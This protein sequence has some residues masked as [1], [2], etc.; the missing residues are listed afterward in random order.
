MAENDVPNKEFYR[1]A[2]WSGPNLAM[3]AG[4]TV[5][6][7]LFAPGF[8][9]VAAGWELAWMWLVPNHPRW[10]R[11]VRAEYLRVRDVK[12]QEELDGMLRR[13]PDYERNK[14]REL[15][16]VTQRIER[17]VEDAPES[18]RSTMEAGVTR[19]RDLLKTYIRMQTS[20]A[21]IR[22]FVKGSEIDD[23]QRQIRKLEQEL[24]DPAMADALRRVKGSNLDV[25]NQRLARALKAHEN[26]RVL[27][28]NQQTIENTLKLIRDNLVSMDNPAGV[29]HQINSVV[30]EMQLNE[31]FMSEMDSF[32]GRDAAVAGLEHLPPPRARA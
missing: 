24:S 26:E 25:L 17:M 4:L 21:R 19:L 8:L 32:L 23:I 10:Q 22:E 20:R 15:E 29:S 18:A 11:R 3:L 16:S 12:D 14:Y 13:L 9:F 30:A 7:A 6:S 5:A 2:F 31:Q 28:A 1:R 27:E